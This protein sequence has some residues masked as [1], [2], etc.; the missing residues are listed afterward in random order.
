MRGAKDTDFGIQVVGRILRVHGRLQGPTL[1]NTLPDLLRNGYVFLADSSQQSGLVSA[2]EKI[3]SIQTGLSQVCP[4][5]FVVNVSGQH[6]I[7]V[8]R[9]GQGELI[10]QPYAPPAWLPPA[11]A[12]G[13][14]L[15]PDWALLQPTLSGFPSPA[16]GSFTPE[17]GQTAVSALAQPPRLPL[18]RD[19]QPLVHRTELLPLST[20][21]LLQCI[22][23]NIAFDE[24]VLTAG[25]RETVKVDRQTVDVFAGSEEIESMQARLSTDE[26][27]RRAQNVLFDADYLDPRELH[28]ALLARLRR[29]FNHHGMSSHVA[30]EELDRALNIIMAA[31]PNLLR[32]A[33]RACAAKFKEVID[34]APLPAAANGLIAGKKSRLNVYGVMPQDLNEPEKQFAEL[35]DADSSGSVSYWFRN[36]SQKPWSIGI[37]MP[38]GERYFPDFAIKV[39]GRS[40]GDGL[41]LVETKGKHILNDEPTINKVQA[42]HKVYGV[43]LMLAQDDSGRFMTVKYL[44]QTGRNAEDQVFRLENLAG[45]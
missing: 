42:E 37:V 33:A 21:D 10:T 18:L 38:G 13:Q 19:G 17:A 31:H 45:Y 6:E 28:D 1:A 15:P 9:D 14:A 26:I 40:R 34:A 43:P 44:E 2:G 36:E 24:K 32:K 27:A 30:P 23:A 39:T 7:Q 8:S 29:E 35:L 12:P 11:T 4:F 16:A 22:A 20:A 25:L 3:N 41:L 5:T